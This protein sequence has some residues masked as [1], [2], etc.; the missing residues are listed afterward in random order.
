MDLKIS[1]RFFLARWA[2]QCR[3][4]VCVLARNTRGAW[5]GSANDRDGGGQSVRVL[6]QHGRGDFPAAALA[7]CVT[8]PT[9]PG[10]HYDPHR[11]GTHQPYICSGKDRLERVCQDAFGTKLVELR[12]ECEHSPGAW[13]F[14]VLRLLS[15]GLAF[16]RASCLLAR[17]DL[18]LERFSSGDSS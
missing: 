18:M 17:A 15:V 4:H 6:E 7:V 16:P 14:G 10:L 2:R 11:T 5:G 1:A 12:R 9:M 13:L 8:K 3:R